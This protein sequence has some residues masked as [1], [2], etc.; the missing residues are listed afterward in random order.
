MTNLVTRFE[1]AF[2]AWLGVRHAFAFWKGRVALY[3]ILRVMGPPQ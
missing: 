2:A 3:A 1:E